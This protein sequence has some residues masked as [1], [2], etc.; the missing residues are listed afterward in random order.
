MF[1]RTLHVK[2]FKAIVDETIDFQVPDA[3]TNGGGLNILVGPNNSGKSSLFEALEFLRNSTKKD[4]NQIVNKK[5]FLADQEMFVEVIFSG[6]ITSV[7]EGFSQKNKKDL[8]KKYIYT[9]DGQEYLKLKRG[10]SDLKELA[11]WSQSEGVYKNE[12]GIAAPVQKLFETNFVWADTNPHDQTSFGATTICGNLL[13]EIMRGFENTSEYSKFKAEFHKTFN[14]EAGALR[15][16]LAEIEK[17]T[18]EIFEEQF[19]K[20]KISFHFDE[21]KVDS[22]FKNTK[23]RIDDGNDT[24]MEEKGSGMQRSVALALLQVYAEKIVAHPEDIDLT[25][26]FFLFIDEPELCLHPQAQKK[27]L[28]AIEDIARTRQVFITT[29]SSYFIDPKLVSKIFKFENI[30]NDQGVKIF[31]DRKSELKV[32]KENRSFFFHHRDIFFTS[33]AIFVEGTTDVERI[34]L[35]CLDNGYELLVK[36]LYFLSGSGSGPHFQKICSIFNIVCYII[37]D[38]DFINTDLE[39]FRL[40]INDPVTGVSSPETQDKEWHRKNFSSYKTTYELRRDGLKKE[41]VFVLSRPDIMDFL[42]KS[43]SGFVGNNSKG[44]STTGTKDEKEK[45]IK[46]VL[47]LI[48]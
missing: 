22:F 10:S 13:K 26:P 19:G 24:F 33:R 15:K 38:V 39:S 41:K 32:M 42:D 47:S 8:L 20:A 27:L 1:L 46:D 34:S 14:D 2:N 5:A 23:I 31:W 40:S 45:E 28:K 4:L 6:N 21:L 44:F 11:C 7:V 17:R 37:Y 3:K 43:G 25:K 16:Q 36:D 12:T 18:Q 9:E 35:F 29:H 48:V 30:D